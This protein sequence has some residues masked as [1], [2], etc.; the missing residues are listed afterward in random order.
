RSDGECVTGS[1]H[2]TPYSLIFSSTAGEEELWLNYALIH[3]VERLPPTSA[4]RFPLHIRCR[5]FLFLTLSLNSL[6]QSIDVF[7]TIQKVACHE[8]SRAWDRYAVESFMSSAWSVGKPGCPWRFTRVNTHYQVC[9]TYPAILAV[10][11]K[12]S[13]TVVSTAAKHRSKGRFPALSY[14]HS[15]NGC[16]ITRSSQPLVGITQSRSVQ[17]ERLVEAI[18]NT[19]PT[20][21]PEDNLIVD[22]RP[23]VNAVV[24]VAMGAGSENT[25]HYGG[26]RKLY[27]GIDNIHV[28]RECLNRIWLRHVSSILSGTREIVDTIHR[29]SGHVLVHCSDGWDRTAQLT[30]LAQ[31]CL[32]PS[33]RTISGL[34]GIVQ[35]E[36]CGFGHKF[37]DRCGHFSHQ[38]AAAMA[39]AAFTGGRLATTIR[40]RVGRGLHERSGYVRET[41]PVFTQFL[42]C[43]YQLWV[44][45]PWSFEW[46]ERLLRW[47]HAE[48]YSC[49]YGTFLGNCEEERQDRVRDRTRS[50]WAWLDAHRSDFTHDL[51][52]PSR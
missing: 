30:S 12:V 5:D 49:R 10:P 23:T 2:L 32:D 51:Y 22:A 50:A 9:P 25:D 29:R 37:T 48:V 31:L 36:W 45:A 1:L 16:S 40:E 20:L 46:D 15:P 35:R 19:A 7:E 3:T 8:D 38:P 13:D 24:N 17:D 27:L 6:R 39:A 44:Q 28:M 47:L 26:C 4:S 33:A 42:D 18:F 14:L 34:I 41:A 21:S 52:N 43:A 11:A